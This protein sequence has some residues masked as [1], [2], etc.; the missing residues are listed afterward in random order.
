MRR[1][2]ELQAYE[3]DP[4]QPSQLDNLPKLAFL[5]IIKILSEESD[6]NILLNLRVNRRLRWHIDRLPEL[7][8]MIAS[9][10][11][12]TRPSQLRTRTLNAESL[13]EAINTLEQTQKQVS[14]A[15][16]GH[17]MEIGEHDE[18]HTVL[19]DKGYRPHTTT[20]RVFFYGSVLYSLMAGAGSGTAAWYAFICC[21]DPCSAG[22]FATITGL[23]CSS[24]NIYVPPMLFEM[25]CPKE[26]I[27]EKTERQLAAAGLE[28]VSPQQAERL[29]LMRMSQN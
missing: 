16:E 23:A 27:T 29:P 22:F 6:K 25:A 7:L 18:I 4:S 20:G 3:F 11:L 12:G 9:A 2:N 10:N 1:Q 15:L 8:C 24:I 14:K 21:C 19:V 13:G 28:G 26:K 17:R 5:K